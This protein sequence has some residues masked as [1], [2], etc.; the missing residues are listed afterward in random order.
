MFAVLP[1]EE[2]NATVIP[3]DKGVEKDKYLHQI[4]PDHVGPRTSPKA[5]RKKRTGGVKW[6]EAD[7]ELA[8]DEK[9]RLKCYNM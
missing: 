9:H 4:P 3:E 7:Y 5:R 2:T 6:T 1:V 8:R